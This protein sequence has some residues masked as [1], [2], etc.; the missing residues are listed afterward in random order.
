MRIPVSRLLGVI[1][2]LGLVSSASG[3]SPGGSIQG[4]VRSQSGE[5]LE[6]ATIFI[7]GTRLGA[8]TRAGG[9]YTIAGVAAG[10]YTVRASRIGF[11][12]REQQ[13]VVGAGAAAV[14]DFALNSAAVTLEQV[15][16]VGYGTQSRRDVTGSVATVSNADIAT[17][18]VARVDQAIA[19][20]VSGRAGADGE[21]AAGCRAPN[22]RAR[23]QFVAG[24][25]RA[26][27][28]GGRCDRRRSQSDQ[29]Q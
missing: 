6:A 24:K 14:A 21:R 25:Q 9:R 18:P 28:G 2:S 26:A 1:L 3:Q 19:G 4:V 12:A 17:M 7:V 27:G 8:Q 15:V 29:P 10:T 13:V 22:P 16:T 20:L 23:R 11:A 5:P